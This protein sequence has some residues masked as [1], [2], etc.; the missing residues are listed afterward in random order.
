MGYGL[1]TALVR[2]GYG[3]VTVWLRLG[4]GLVTA[5]V[6]LGYGLGLGVGFGKF[7]SFGFGV[8]E[9]WTISDSGW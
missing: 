5:W 1:D 4:Y 8:S 6:R 9:F 2:F 7:R 3:L